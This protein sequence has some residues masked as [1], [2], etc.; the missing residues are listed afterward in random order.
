[1]A[2]ALVDPK[3]AEGVMKRGAVLASDDEWNLLFAGWGLLAAAAHGPGETKLAYGLISNELG[4]EYIH[5]VANALPAAA[6]LARGHQKEA[7]F[8]RAKT[9]HETTRFWAT[10]NGALLA[11][12]LCAEPPE[13]RR[14]V[15]EL[16][17]ANIKIDQA[18]Y[19]E[20]GL[21]AMALAASNEAERQEAMATARPY[22]SAE[23]NE[24]IR[25][26][27]IVSM[28]IAACPDPA[29]ARRAGATL[30]SGK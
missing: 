14:E 24:E 30:I 27:A 5:E 18:N 22:L 29:L 21:V 15:F 8:E 1:V 3:E 26:A 25:Q 16:A 2:R 19:I 10:S 13:Q 9:T 20:T 6:I 11:M 7:L 12:A 4:S 28:G 23:W 17:K